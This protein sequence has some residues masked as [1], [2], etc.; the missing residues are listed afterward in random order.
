MAKNSE[1]TTYEEYLASYH[2]MTPP[3]TREKWEEKE[4]EKR[5]WKEFYRYEKQK[6]PSNPST[7]ELPVAIKHDGLKSRFE[8]LPWD[9]LAEVAKVYQFGMEKYDARNWEKGF[10]WLRLWNA[11]MRHMTDWEAGESKDPETSLSH[12]VHAAF[13]ILG[14]I[15]HELRHIGTDDRHKPIKTMVEEKPDEQ[16]GP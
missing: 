8:L 10:D 9:A 6:N 14:L 7:N 3:L 4:H 2:G 1:P 11:G 16:H 15:A 5:H 12:L 13:C